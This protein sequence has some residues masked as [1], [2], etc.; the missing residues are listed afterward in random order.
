MTVPAGLGLHV[1][2]RVRIEANYCC[3]SPLYRVSLSYFVQIKSAGA[4]SAVVAFPLLS[5]TQSS[6]LP[7][8]PQCEVFSKNK[9]KT[10]GNMEVQEIRVPIFT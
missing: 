7:A 10:S 5:S 3:L 4:Q 2:G 8:V 9:L 6:P 1:V